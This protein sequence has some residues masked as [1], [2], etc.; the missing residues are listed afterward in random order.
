MKF[1][2]DIRNLLK[3]VCIPFSLTIIVLNVLYFDLRQPILNMTPIIKSNT[4]QAAVV[5]RNILDSSN[6]G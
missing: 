1:Y 3:L 2:F 6:L 5:I 4:S